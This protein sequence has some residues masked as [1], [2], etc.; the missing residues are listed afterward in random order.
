LKNKAEVTLYIRQE[1]AQQNHSDSLQTDNIPEEYRVGIAE[2]II[3][4]I[5]EVFRFE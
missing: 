3:N 4:I 5:Q 2:V 1:G